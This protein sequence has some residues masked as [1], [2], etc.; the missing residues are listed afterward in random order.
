MQQLPTLLAQQCSELLHPF[1]RGFKAPKH[2]YNKNLFKQPSL[3][4][5]WDHFLPLWF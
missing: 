3:I 2:L 4:S 5:D 1:A